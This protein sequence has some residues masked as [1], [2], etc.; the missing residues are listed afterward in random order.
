MTN[1]SKPTPARVAQFVALLLA[2]QTVLNTQ[3]D[4]IP[5]TNWISLVLGLG[6]AALI[7]F[8]G[9]KDK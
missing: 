5:Y 4:P 3:Q 8:T 9:T 1:I 6:S 2:F 7:V